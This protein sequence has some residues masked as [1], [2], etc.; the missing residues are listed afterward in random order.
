MLVQDHPKSLLDELDISV[1]DIDAQHFAYA[2]GS[3]AANTQ[4]SQ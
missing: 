2:A 1:I 3:Y 4:V